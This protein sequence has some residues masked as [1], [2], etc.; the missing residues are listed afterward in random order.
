MK[1]KNLDSDDGISLC[2]IKDK[3]KKIIDIKIY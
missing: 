1:K 3:K 2:N